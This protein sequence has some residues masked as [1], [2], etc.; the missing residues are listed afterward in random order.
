MV[1]GGCCSSVAEHWQLIPEALGSI[2]RG[3]TFLSFPLS[4]Q[5]S[6]DSNDPDYLSLD[7]YR[8]LDMGEPRPL[9]SLAVISL[10]FLRIHK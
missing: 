4:F 3:T 6:S 5:R 8:C 9:G 10:R 2:L 1:V 7:L